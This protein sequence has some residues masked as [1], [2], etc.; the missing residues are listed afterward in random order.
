MAKYIAK[1]IVAAFC[2]AQGW[3]GWTVETVPG[4]G[5]LNDVAFWDESHGWICGDTGLLWRYDGN[6]W[7]KYEHNLTAKNLNAVSFGSDNWHYGC[8]GGDDGTLLEYDG[9]WRVIPALNPTSIYDTYGYGITAGRFKNGKVWRRP[10][11]EW[12]V[13]ETPFPEALYG[14]TVSG[15]G[16]PYNDWAV[17]ENGTI[18]VV[19]GWYKWE[20]YFSPTTRNL[21]AVDFDWYYFG[22]AC[23]DGGTMIFYGPREWEIAPVPTTEDLFDVFVVSTEDAWAVGAGN[24]ILRY[25]NGS[26]VKD[27]SPAPTGTVL[28]AVFFPTPDEGWAV[29][30]AGV[31]PVVLH[32][33]V[34]PSI[35]PASLGRIKALFGKTGR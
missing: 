13:E 6:R 22:F 34:S 25:R 21:R 1:V 15:A 9:E 33:T 31:T 7:V 30:N 5:V 27:E 17:G 29:G 16:W 8:C 2:A 19:T 28:R 24:T 32:Y 23:G 20:K 4:A 14:V 3:A 11:D 12:I 18:A 26:W 35:C 10:G